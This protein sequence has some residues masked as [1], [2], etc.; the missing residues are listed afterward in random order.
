MVG[1]CQSLQYPL[2]TASF[3]E[4]VAKT[5]KEW[6]VPGI[7]I[8]VVHNDEGF[9]ERGYGIATFPSEKVT[10]FTLFDTGSTTKAFVG[11]AWAQFIE[12]EDSQKK[13]P[14]DN[15]SYDTPPVNLIRDDFVL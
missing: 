8:A 11:T 1:A 7:S 4:R 13:D 6:H 10:L 3:E 12:P 9:A 14:R 15:I 5:L 2:L